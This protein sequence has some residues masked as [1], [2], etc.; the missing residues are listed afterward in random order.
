M[1]EVQSDDPTFKALLE[2]RT[3]FP[4]GTDFD[5]KPLITIV[6]TKD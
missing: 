6:K 1:F 3:R 5:A 2:K 4:S